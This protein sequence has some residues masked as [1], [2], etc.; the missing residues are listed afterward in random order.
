M[1]GYTPPSIKWYPVDRNIFEGNFI[2]SKLGEIL[3][4]L[5][6]RPGIFDIF[7]TRQ[8]SMLESQ[9]LIRSDKLV[10]EFMSCTELRHRPKH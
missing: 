8:A 6:Q 7:R 9:R 3:M 5:F 4:S 2:T 1:L 10:F